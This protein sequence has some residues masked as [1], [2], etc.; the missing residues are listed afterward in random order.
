[1]APAEIDAVRV[2]AI[3]PDK[4]TDEI[5]A[6]LGGAERLTVEAFADRRRGRRRPAPEK[7]PYMLVLGDR[8]VEARS[9]TVRPR[10]A[11]KGD[12]QETLT[13]DALAERLAVE[14]AAR[15]A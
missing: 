14:A 4:L 13:W 2:P 7:I 15:G 11:E 6:L 5:E 3:S 12:A 1:M 10:G 8:E 9:A